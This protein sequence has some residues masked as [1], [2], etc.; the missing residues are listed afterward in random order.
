MD[1]CVLAARKSIDSF[2]FGTIVDMS[3]ILIHASR[4]YYRLRQQPQWIFLSDGA[5]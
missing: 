2:L 3:V 1:I 4:A 5:I